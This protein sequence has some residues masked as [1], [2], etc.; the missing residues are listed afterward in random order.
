MALFSEAEK[1]C[2]QIAALPTYKNLVE[3]RE[4]HN[5]QV[6]RDNSKKLTQLFL[7]V[8][9]LIR[10]VLVVQGGVIRKKYTKSDGGAI[11]A[12]I[13]FD[14]FEQHLHSA[15]V[16]YLPVWWEIKM[17]LDARGLNKRQQME[18]LQIQ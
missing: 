18:R 8:C 17:F 11:Y 15:V 1:I 2:Q 6:G 13:E 12:A 7:E 3:V 5:A 4:K 9:S 14:E 10:S 16:I